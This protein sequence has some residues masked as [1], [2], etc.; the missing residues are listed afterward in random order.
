MA[1]I[2]QA[3]AYVG[4]DSGI[5]HLA[6]RLAPSLVLFGPSD[7]VVWGPLGPRVKTVRAPAAAMDRLSPRRVKD[8]LGELM[9]ST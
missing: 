3:R 9:G 5:S 2:G 8:A 1:L 7:P 6:A 4:N